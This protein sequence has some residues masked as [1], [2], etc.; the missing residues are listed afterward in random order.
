MNGSLRNAAIVRSAL[1]SVAATA[2]SAQFERAPKTA[3]MPG[4]FFG[5]S[6]RA[7]SNGR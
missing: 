2:H 1:S 5:C 4:T 3:A 6:A 7:R